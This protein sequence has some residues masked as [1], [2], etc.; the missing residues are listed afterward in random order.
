VENNEEKTFQPALDTH[1]ISV[2]MVFERI[3]AQGAE[4]FLRG[5]PEDLQKFWER[6]QQMKAEH[7]SLNDVFVQELK[8]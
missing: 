3:D 6:F 8:I 5:A 2:G 4:D 7:N 1:R